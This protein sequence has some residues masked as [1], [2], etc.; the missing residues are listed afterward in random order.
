MSLHCAPCKA[1]ADTIARSILVP[2]RSACRVCA[3]RRTAAR[4][5]GAHLPPRCRTA[6]QRSGATIGSARI[7]TVEIKS[8]KRY[9]HACCS[10]FIYL[11]WLMGHHL[12][13][14]NRGLARLP[15]GCNTV[16]CDSQCIKNGRLKATF[17]TYK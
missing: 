2:P 9:S 10:A 11:G 12:P 1:S 4:A 3:Q 15:R 14:S 16:M 17:L 5:A 13:T 6:T 8:K 7:P